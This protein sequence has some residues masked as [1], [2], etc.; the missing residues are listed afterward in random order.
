MVLL[1]S[2][3]PVSFGASTPG[4]PLVGGAFQSAAVLTTAG[5]AGA[6][7]GADAGGA[8]GGVVAA[9]GAPGG[10]ADDAHPVASAVGKVARSRAVACTGTRR[11]VISVLGAKGTGSR[12]AG[13]NY[14]ERKTLGSAAIA[15][16]VYSGSSPQ[17]SWPRT[18]PVIRS[19]G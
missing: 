11:F 9:A 13:E 14:P 7:A 5:A 15:R 10:G 17:T 12:P 2:S 8:A 16:A 4:D 6:A 19:W 3:L 1:S 18:Y